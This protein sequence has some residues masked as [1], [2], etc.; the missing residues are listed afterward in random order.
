LSTPSATALT[1]VVVTGPP[2][3]YPFP[4][5]YGPDFP[6][7]KML[8][9]GGHQVFESRT[10]QNLF[11]DENPFME[12]FDASGTLTMATLLAYVSTWQERAA[13]LFELIGAD[14]KDIDW[15]GFHDEPNWEA[16]PGCTDLLNYCGSASS[17]SFL[18]SWWRTQY[19]RGLGLAWEQWTDW[20]R[21]VAESR[22][23]G[24]LDFVANSGGPHAFVQTLVD[25]V[26]SFPALVPEVWL[27]AV[28]PD[29]TV[30]DERHL[31][32]NPQRVD[33]V[34]LANGKKCVIEIDGPSG[35]YADYDEGTHTYSVNEALYAKNL[36]IERSLRRQGW[37]IH[38]FANV[39]V[40]GVGDEEFIALVSYLPGYRAN[41]FFG[42][43]SVTGESLKAAMGNV[44]KYMLPF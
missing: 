44:D 40:R 39:E 24:T 22:G 5:V 32:E 43:P 41:T 6:E 20:V 30:E 42:T 19:A 25:L 28:G 7:F 8:M 14:D 38:R 31:G 27:N 4:I 26:F 16:C 18:L 15:H 35:H 23:R 9:R 21:R 11:L 2:S 1:F 37:E 29:R 13:T 3:G 10:N 34:L 36:K 17:R 33:F 12:D